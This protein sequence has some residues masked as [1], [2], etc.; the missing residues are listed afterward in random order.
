MLLC[1]VFATGIYRRPSL[2]LCQFWEEFGIYKH[3]SLRWGWKSA[4]LERA[5]IHKL[6][7]C[8]EDWYSHHSVDWMNGWMVDFFTTSKNIGRFVKKQIH[9]RECLIWFI[10]KPGELKILNVVLVHFA[11]SHLA[12]CYLAMLCMVWPNDNVIG[13]KF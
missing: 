11:K 1:D 6:C 4:V 7:I 2:K 5:A 3:F 9:N 12:K 13:R 10:G 8:Y